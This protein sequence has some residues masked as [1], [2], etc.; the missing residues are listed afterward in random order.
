MK[1][2]HDSEEILPIINEKDEVIGKDSRKRI[3]EQ[4]LLH[5]E[6]YIYII[7]NQN[8][9]L[10]QKRTDYKIWDH[11][12]GGHV[13]LNHTYEE[14]AIMELFEELGLNIKQKELVEIGKERFFSPKTGNDRIAKI[15]IVKKEIKLEELKID[16][17]EVLEVKYFNK[18][19][20][21]KLFENENNTSSS[22][23]KIINE[24]ILKEIN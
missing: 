15:F 9:V 23:R 16:K 18:N 5:R 1:V 2:P 7:N 10:L 19:K 4:K 14:T 17:A 6:V 20:L 8:E 3:H 22:M 21:E 24:H 13:P 11:S 12:V